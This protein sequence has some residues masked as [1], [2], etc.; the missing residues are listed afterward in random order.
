PAPDYVAFRDA[1]SKRILGNVTRH[2]RYRI[3]RTQQPLYCP[4][5][6]GE[7]NHGYLLGARVPTIMGDTAF[8]TLTLECA[9][10]PCAKGQPCVWGSI[11]QRQTNY[12]LVR[13][14]GEW[15]VEKA[16]SGATVIAM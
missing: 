8:A 16:L 2:D 9:G 5:V 4:G 10:V 11:V 13:T 7:G 15:K 12:L 6:S 3:A 1:L 14:N